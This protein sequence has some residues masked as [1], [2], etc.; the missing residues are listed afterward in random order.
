M[1]K[2]KPVNHSTRLEELCPGF[3]CISEP[4]NVYSKDKNV[5]ESE[6]RIAYAIRAD[7]VKNGTPCKLVRYKGMGFVM[8][9]KE[10]LITDATHQSRRTGSYKALARIFVDRRARV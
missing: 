5:A 1:K 3:A 9:S 2:P 10:G 4:L 8:R 6:I 7:Q